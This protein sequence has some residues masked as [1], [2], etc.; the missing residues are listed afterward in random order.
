MFI[1]PFDF[2][3]PE[4]FLVG[5]VGLSWFIEHQKIVLKLRCKYGRAINMPIRVSRISSDN[6]LILYVN[7]Y[8]FTGRK[9]VSWEELIVRYFYS[10]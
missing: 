3:V 8:D 5:I 2:S 4:F 7:Y 1:S 10:L 6:R 9:Y